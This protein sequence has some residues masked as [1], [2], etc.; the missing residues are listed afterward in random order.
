MRPH[1]GQAKEWHKK[2]DAEIQQK[3][4]LECLYSG[5]DGRGVADSLTLMATSLAAV[6]IT[7]STYVPAKV[8]QKFPEPL[9]FLT[10]TETKA[11]TR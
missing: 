3:C 5:R 9:V 4:P 8:H 6:L 2:F 7:K 1:R 11:L 10:L